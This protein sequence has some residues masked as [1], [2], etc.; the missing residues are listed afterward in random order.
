MDLAIASMKHPIK[1][2]IGKKEETIG[3]YNKTI[4][5]TGRIEVVQSSRKTELKGF[6][7]L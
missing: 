7:Y 3:S 5:R 4:V 2:R 1:M 6:K